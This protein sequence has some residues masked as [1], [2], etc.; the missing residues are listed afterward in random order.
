MWQCVQKCATH[1]R[2]ITIK[3][4]QGLPHC[5]TQLK[6]SHPGQKQIKHNE[7]HQNQSEQGQS[8]CRGTYIVVLLLI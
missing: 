5:R 4:K 3:R 1:W 7:H 8:H 2:A 6:Q